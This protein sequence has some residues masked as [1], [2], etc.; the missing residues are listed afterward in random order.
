MT[1]AGWLW[2]SRLVNTGSV[3]EHQ[4]VQEGFSEGLSRLLLGTR[5]PPFGR[6]DP[7]ASFQRSPRRCLRCRKLLEPCFCSKPHCC[8]FCPWSALHHRHRLSRISPRFPPRS[9][10]PELF[11]LCSAQ[12][13]LLERR[14][15]HL[16]LQGSTLLAG[17]LYR[18]MGEATSGLC[19]CS[20]MGHVG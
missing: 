5:E 20:A 11:S 17:K 19:K 12:G 16:L 8:C 15:Q 7:T 9:P 2:A 13:T 18:S 4:D 1:Q 14:E 3:S 6:Q 10:S